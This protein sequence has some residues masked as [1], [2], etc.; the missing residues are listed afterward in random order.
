MTT[1]T[2][3][4]VNKRKTSV[5]NKRLFFRG[6]YMKEN[7][8][9]RLESVVL[10]SNGKSI[11]DYELLTSFLLPNHRMAQSRAMANKLISCFGNIG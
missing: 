11:D 6:F 10:S 4:E 2:R 7:E 5:V 9:K 8:K 1:N 3:T